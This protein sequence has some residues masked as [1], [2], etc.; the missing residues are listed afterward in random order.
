M[1]SPKNIQRD[2]RWTKPETASDLALA[3]ETTII[4]TTIK[5]N[6]DPVVYVDM[7]QAHISNAAFAITTANQRCIGCYLTPPVGDNVP[8]RVKASITAFGQP[9]YNNDQAIVIGYA[10]AVITGTDDIIED[11]YYIPF[12]SSFDDL[13]IVPA[14]VSGDPF[15]GRALCIALAC[16]TAQASNHVLGSISVQSLGVKPPTMQNAVS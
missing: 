3:T 1:S 14:L 12:Q 4:T 6:A 11:P 2:G 9:V 15:F 13:I 7:A 8:Y 10:P 5:V 16:Q